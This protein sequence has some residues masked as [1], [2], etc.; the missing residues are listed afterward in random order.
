MDEYK[1]YVTFFVTASDGRE[2]ELAVVEEFEFE[3]NNYVAAAEVIGD[4]ISENGV[5]IFKTIIGEDDFTV[6]KIEDPAEYEK[7]IKA[8]MEM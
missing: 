8:Y 3:K 6:E 2:V 5:F 4:A 7:V 1:E